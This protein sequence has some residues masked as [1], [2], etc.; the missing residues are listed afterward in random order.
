MIDQNNASPPKEIDGRM[1]YLRSSV[2]DFR[3]GLGDDHHSAA[4]V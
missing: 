2:A 1:K 3:F 4:T